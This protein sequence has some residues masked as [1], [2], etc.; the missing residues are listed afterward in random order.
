KRFWVEPATAEDEAE[1]E[2]AAGPLP[3][4]EWFV[5]PAWRQVAAP[6]P[7][8]QMEGQL[9]VIGTGAPALEL[10]GRLRATGFDGRLADPAAP[11]SFFADGTVPPRV[12]YAAAWAGAPAG[13]DPDAAWTAQQAGFFGVLTLSQALAAA[14]PESPVHLDILTAGTH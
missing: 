3:V 10:A 13:P 8:G 11:E 4:E 2:G 6:P 9:L 14:Q 1:P 12:V 5:V 7:A